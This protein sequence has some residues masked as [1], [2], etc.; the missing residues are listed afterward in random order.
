MALSSDG[1]S[2][3]LHIVAD[4]PWSGSD[5]QLRSLQEKMHNYVVYAEDGQL[6]AA[7]PETVGMAW[8]IVVTSYAGPPDAR[9]AELLKTAA[10]VIRR[11]GGDLRIG[12]QPV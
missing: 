7:Y 3:E 5:D 6:A 9:T 10:P 11:Y 8:V 2:V 1:A 12:D 4:D